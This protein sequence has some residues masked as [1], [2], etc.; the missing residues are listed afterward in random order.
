MSG[1]FLSWVFRPISVGARQLVRQDGLSGGPFYGAQPLQPTQTRAPTGERLPISSRK[2]DSQPLPDNNS[3]H[4]PPKLVIGVGGHPLSGTRETWFAPFDSDTLHARPAGS[5]P[6]QTLARWL[7]PDTDSRIGK[8]RTGPDLEERP[9][10][11]SMSPN[12]AIPAEKSIRFSPLAAAQPLNILS[13]PETLNASGSRRACRMAIRRN[14]CSLLALP[15]FPEFAQAVR[16]G[17]LASGKLWKG[18][19]DS[20]SETFR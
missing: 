12:Q 8:D 19:R 2:A 18:G 11:I 5:G 7:L 15:D 14:A 6:A 20:N 4:K 17:V 10:S 16:Y 13:R 1:W 3:K 9:L